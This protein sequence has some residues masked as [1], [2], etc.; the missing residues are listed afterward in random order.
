VRSSARGDRGHRAE[1]PA[2]PQDQYEDQHAERDEVAHAV[3]PERDPKRLED[4]EQETPSTAPPLIPVHRASRRRTPSVP[5]RR[6]RWGRRWTCT[7][8]RRHR[9]ARRARTRS[10]TPGSGSSAP[11]C[12]LQRRVRVLRGGADGA[13]GAAELQVSGSAAMTT[14]VIPNITTSEV[15]KRRRPAAGRCRQRGWE[16]PHPRPKT[17]APRCPGSATPPPSPAAPR[18]AG[19][20]SGARQHV[21]QYRARRSHEHAEHGGPQR[22]AAFGDEP[23][24]RHEPMANTDPCAKFATCVTPKISENPTATSAYALPW[25]RPAKRC[26]ASVPRQLFS[27]NLPP[28]TTS[29]RTLD[30]PGGAGR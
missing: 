8:R 24:T 27:T 25:I 14:M 3:A 2:G 4:A 30:R 15:P 28:V 19:L 22:P 1:Q 5:A 10:R 29:S 6:L 26:R 7:C 9:P 20:A 23:P 16:G 11:G 12:H 18:W 13:P 21:D 17:A